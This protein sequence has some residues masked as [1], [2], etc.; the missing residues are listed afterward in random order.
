M[1]D[2]AQMNMFSWICTAFAHLIIGC[3]I[4]YLKPDVL[5]YVH[6][7]R[8]YSNIALMICVFLSLRCLIYFSRGYQAHDIMKVTVFT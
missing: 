2:F 5:H 8:F 7:R 1:E 6:M 3:A 4:R